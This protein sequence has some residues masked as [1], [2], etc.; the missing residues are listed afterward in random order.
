MMSFASF[1]DVVWF[2]G[3][4]FYLLAEGDCFGFVMVSIIA[5]KFMCALLGTVNCTIPSLDDVG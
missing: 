4:V 2:L 1:I 5:R 3:N